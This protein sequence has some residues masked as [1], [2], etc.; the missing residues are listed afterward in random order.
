MWSH[1]KLLHQLCSCAGY[2]PCATVITHFNCSAFN[3]VYIKTFVI[4]LETPKIHAKGQRYKIRNTWSYNKVVHVMQIVCTHF[5]FFYDCVLIQEQSYDHVSKNTCLFTY[6]FP[7]GDDDVHWSKQAMS[8]VNIVL[9]SYTY[10]DG[11]L[12]FAI[13]NIH[14]AIKNWHC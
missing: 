14:R 4:T 13:C 12:L 7:D 1:W 5:I 8:F 6:K 9:N 10:C 2:G 11:V 3:T